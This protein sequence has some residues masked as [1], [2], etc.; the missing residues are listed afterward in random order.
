MKIQPINYSVNSKGVYFTTSKP[1]RPITELVTRKTKNSIIK[2]SEQGI[3]YAED[4]KIKP[5]IKEKFNRINWINKLAENKDVFV[6]FK[7][8]RKRTKDSPYKYETLVDIR[9][10]GKDGLNTEGRI[11]IGA[12]NLTAESAAKNMFSQLRKRNY[13][14]YRV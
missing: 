12:S 10:L 4:T 3:R 2:T 6:F 5:E 1:M 8:I 14:K 9:Y 7:T 13:A 11:V